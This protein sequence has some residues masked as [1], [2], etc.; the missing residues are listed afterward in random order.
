LDYPEE[1]KKQSMAVLSMY[2]VYK[3]Q[4]VTSL[5]PRLPNSAE[6]VAVKLKRKVAY[7]GHYMYEYVRPKLVMDALRWLQENN[8][9]YNDINVC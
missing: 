8:Q 9:L 4:Q 7:K 6:V 3:L 1:D 5:L 2:H